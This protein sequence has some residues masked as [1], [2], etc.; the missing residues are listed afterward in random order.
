VKKILSFL[1][2]STIVYAGTSVTVVGSHKTV[3]QT[4]SYITTP[5]KSTTGGS[6]THG[7]KNTHYPP[8]YTGS[9]SYRYYPK[10]PP[11]IKVTIVY[12]S[13][14]SEEDS[15]DGKK[16]RFNI[17]FSKAI[18]KDITLSYEIVSDDKNFEVLKDIKQSSSGSITVKKG[19]K[20]ADIYLDV[21]DDLQKEDT[22]KFILKIKKPSGNFSLDN[23]TCQAMIIDNDQDKQVSKASGDYI[24]NGANPIDTQISSLDP[25]AVTIQGKPGF[26]VVTYDGYKTS[27]S[28]GSESC[29]VDG[30]KKVCTR[31]CTTTTYHVVETSDKMTIDAVI[32]HRFKEYDP[33]KQE[34]SQETSVILNDNFTKNSSSD[35]KRN[36]YTYKNTTRT[37]TRSKMP[38]FCS[39]LS[40]ISTDIFDKYCKTDTNRNQNTN[41]NRNDSSNAKTKYIS[42][43]SGNSKTVYVPLDT[44][45]RCVYLEVLG[46]S[47]KDKN[48]K[49]TQLRGVSDT[50]AIRPKSFKINIKD[51]ITASKNFSFSVNALSNDLNQTFGYSQLQNT[52]FSVRVK[53]KLYPTNKL[54]ITNLKFSDG[55]S[56]IKTLAYDEAGVLDISVQEDPLN[57]YA[58]VDGSKSFI[59]SDVK[60]VSFIPAKFDV[61]YSIGYEGG[62]SFAMFSNSVEDMNSRLKLHIKALNAKGDIMTRYTKNGHSHDTTLTFKQL[63]DKSMAYKMYYK[64]G[65]KEKE[66]DIK[67]SLQELSFVIPKEDFKSGELIEDIK[68]SFARESNQ[69]QDPI[70]LTTT[71]VDIVD[72]N[73][74]TVVGSKSDTVK[75]YHYY[76]RA[77]VAPNPVKVKGKEL[78]ASVYYEIYCKNC[79]K[80]KFN[81]ADNKSSLDS[82]YWYII[83]KS[84]YQGKGICDIKDTIDSANNDGN[85]IIKERVNPNEIYIKIKQAPYKNKIIYTPKF[86]YLLFDRIDPNVAKHNFIVKF[87]AGDSNWAGEGE[88][89]KTVDTNISK[90]GVQGID[91]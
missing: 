37:N 6:N 52:T 39:G 9:S 46:H 35:K 14:F 15:K 65:S 12:Y 16:M 74:T 78:S 62:A 45:Y 4:V 29:S 43:N 41:Q 77:H 31:E 79:Q 19:S 53:D 70:E 61:E 23:S 83:P 18:P 56:D 72:N 2:T 89:G 30:N 67:D 5:S 90:I 20:S 21:V 76:A 51:T 49:V 69:P 44:A 75:S 22:E 3:Q 82:V 55:I 91:W 81:L 71:K 60:S 8:N 87:T 7:H 27:R 36:R 1:I 11:S 57:Y 84:L 68:E 50:F 64:Y 10:K 28:C 59:E 42:I 17:A 63:I 66:T 73:F 26:E 54:N 33:Q 40:F 47:D 85:I 86:K 80:T 13:I 48:G 25:L 32:M 38:V 58:I 88:L 24:I 34:C